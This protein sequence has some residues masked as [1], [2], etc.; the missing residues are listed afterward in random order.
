MQTISLVAGEYLR[1]ETG[2][3][4]IDE[5]G[6]A[7]VAQVD[8]DVDVNDE[9]YA[10]VWANIQDDRTIRGVDPETGLPLPP[11]DPE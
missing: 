2:T 9:A 4:V 6:F 11:P 1:S 10:A 5:H 7:T 3:H 8:T